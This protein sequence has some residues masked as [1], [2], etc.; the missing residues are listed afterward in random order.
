MTET[1]SVWRT[2]LS[3]LLIMFLVPDVGRAQEPAATDDKDSTVPY[4]VEGYL[5]CDDLS[6]M[7]EGMDVYSVEETLAD[8]CADAHRQHEAALRAEWASLSMECEDMAPPT[9][10]E[11]SCVL[12][13]S[14]D[15]RSSTAGQCHYRVAI[16][17]EFADGR[18]HGSARFARSRWAATRAAMKGIRAQEAHFGPIRLGTKRTVSERVVM[19]PCPENGTGVEGCR[20]CRFKKLSPEKK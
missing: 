3:A 10:Y 13:E 19:I 16:S 14:K 17:Y 4:Q 18:R 20:R 7:L 15:Q 1:P 11:V 12:E 6:E 9:Y 2:I 5:E 8:H